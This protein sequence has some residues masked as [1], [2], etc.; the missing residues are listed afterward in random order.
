M[1][2][3]SSRTELLLGQGKINLI[4]KKRIILF[5]VG[6][7]GSWC[8]ESL[9]RSGVELLTIVD[10]DVIVSSNI[11]RQLM[12]R[13]KTVGET[14]VDAMKNRLLE[15]NPSA[16]VSAIH[17]T[18]SSATVDEFRLEDYDYIID[19]IDSVNDKALLL[20]K[21]S[22]F[23]AQIFSSMGAALKLDPSKIRVAEFWQVR[24][25]PLG[26][27]L[28]KKIRHASGKLSKPVSCVYSEETLKNA[29]GV[30]N[31]E[32]LPGGNSPNGSIVHVTAVFGFILAGL[33]IQH[34]IND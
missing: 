34:I 5:G 1:T 26:A 13:Q 4:R 7:V 9:V 21:G 29:G 2:D 8:A 18:F 19:C 11:N 12:A 6:G 17:K 32:V 16:S 14:K 25:C 20:M 10:G 23:K 33:V 28:R 24:G 30:Y 27:A 31:E 3:F 22:S 15:I